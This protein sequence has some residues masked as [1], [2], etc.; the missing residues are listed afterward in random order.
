[1]IF[2]VLDN[3][4]LCY[5][6]TCHVTHRS[7]GRSNHWECLTSSSMIVLSNAVVMVPF[8]PEKIQVAFAFF[9]E[10]ASKRI[11][12]FRVLERFRVRSSFSFQCS[13]NGALIQIESLGDLAFIVTS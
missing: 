13:T 9:F 10:E 3:V 11:L 5:K 6:L 7:E 8:F 2:T 1:M 12:T 4:Y